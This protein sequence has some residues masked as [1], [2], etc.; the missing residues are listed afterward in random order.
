[1]YF[2]WVLV[3]FTILTGG[4][5]IA[6]LVGIAAGHAYYFLEYVYPEAGGRQFLAT[7]QI[8]RCHHP[9]PLLPRPLALRTRVSGG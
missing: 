8:F 6:E 5:P 1:M 2:P 9:P 7:P 3:G 4:S